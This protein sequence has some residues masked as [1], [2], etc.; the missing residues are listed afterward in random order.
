MGSLTPLYT[1]QPIV[2]L[3]RR[4]VLTSGFVIEFIYFFSL[5]HSKENRHKTKKNLFDRGFN[6]NAMRIKRFN[7]IMNNSDAFAC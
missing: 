5:D 3:L 4:P 1:E 7:A 6:E 2:L